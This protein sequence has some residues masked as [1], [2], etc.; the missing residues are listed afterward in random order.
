[1]PDQANDLRRLVRHSAGAD[2]P[3]P[4]AR[5]AIIVVT[6]GKGGVGTT[7]IAVNVAMAIAECKLRTVLLDADLCGGDAATLCGL[8]ERYTLADVLD[9]R[10][11]L[12]E[13]LQAGPGAVRLL[14]GIWQS[15]DRNGM[16]PAAAGRLLGQ[17]ATLA[18]DVDLAVLDAGNRPGQMM[19]P[20]C[21][22]AEVVLTVTTPQPASII[23]TYAS[24][25]ALRDQGGSRPIHSLVNMAPGAS[26]AEDVQR[27]LG[28][29]C[30]RFL[31]VHLMA[32]GHVSAD[33]HVPAAAAAA[34]PFVIAAA[35]CQ[36][37]RQTAGLARRLM[38]AVGRRKVA[39]DGAEERQ[40][41][42]TA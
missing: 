42:L 7:T 20:L 29:A 24:I 21:R 37:A 2:A 17:L 16:S 36:S 15:A 26:T 8:D 33:P 11:T 41:R 22:A 39:A 30:R 18:A 4:A 3:H 25:K 34:E 10:R 5:P 32:A 35:G 19:R 31:A 27:R 9:G 14:P 12:A 23:G 28:T 38:A 13:A 40:L 6:G 1:M